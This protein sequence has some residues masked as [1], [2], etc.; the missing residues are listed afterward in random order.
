MGL[1]LCPG[2]VTPSA[3]QSGEGREAVAVIRGSVFDAES[4]DPLPNATVV[5]R[6]SERLVAAMVTDVSGQFAFER[7]EAGSYVL[8]TSYIGYDMRRDSLALSAGDTITLVIDLAPSSEQMQELVVEDARS[9]GDRFVAGLETITAA[10]LKRVPMPDVSYDLAGYLQT[11]PGVVSTGDRG[12][13]LFVRGGTPTQNLILLDGMPVYQPF[14]IV[15]FYSAFPADIISFT[16]VYAGG[17]GARY[18]GRISS[19]IDIHTR[20]GSKDRFRGTASVA[21]FLSGIQVEFPVKE[22]ESSLILSIRE[23]IIDRVSKPLLGEDLP[24]RFGDRFLKFHA[25]LNQTSNFSFTGL[26]SY[27]EGNIA[28]TGSTPSSARNRK[29]TWKNQAYGG[30]YTYIPPEAAVMF[31]A[32]ANY[33]RLDSRYRLTES[34]LREASVA[35]GTA[36]MTFAYLLGASDVYFGIFGGVDS[37]DWDLGSNQLPESS[38]VSSGGGFI[39]G[40]FVVNEFVRLEPSA[41]VE[42]FSRGQGRYF[43][44]RGRVIFL[45]AGSGGRNR[46]SLAAGR[47]RQQ[48]VGINNQQDVSEVF[49]IWAASPKSTPVPQAIHF[50][51][52]W[53]NRVLPWLEFKTEAYVKRLENLSFPVFNEAVNRVNEYAIVD[54][55]ARGVDLSVELTRRAFSLGVNYSLGRVVYNRP[56]QAARSIFSS[57]FTTGRRVGAEVFNPPHDRRHQLNAVGQVRFGNNAILGRWVFGSGLPFTRIRGYYHVVSEIEPNNRDFLKIPGIDAVSTGELYDDRLPTYHRLDISYERHF[58][59]GSNRAVLHAG[60]VNAYDRANIFEYN[61]FTA[62]RVDQLPIIPS[63]GMRVEFQ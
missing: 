41:R 62:E 14:H 42:A 60:L 7:L 35:G 29:S 53:D 2:P 39:E 16:D 27:D 10:D 32:K 34:E 59:F 57:G 52:G 8:R 47:Y 15:G 37:F 45:P 49:T 54:G 63:F 51:V 6:R 13:Q 38:G 50:I 48:I 43:D 24:F 22:G 25:H 9:G 58:V 20:N 33:S 1:V 23:S 26:T 18:G 30:K 61:I 21:P 17:F 31:E 28:I 5:L 19:V 55:S 36:S 40:R 4:G 46:F 12:G 44:P 56:E 3:A 11:L